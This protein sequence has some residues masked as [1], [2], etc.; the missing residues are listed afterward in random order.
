MNRTVFLDRDGVIMVNRPQHVR[1]WSDVEFLPGA[2]EGLA[3]LAR[4]TVDVVVVTNQAIVNRGQA[5]RAAVDEIH[6]RML[7]EIKRHGGGIRSVEVCPHR[8]DEGCGCRKPAPGLLLRAATRYGIRLSNAILVGDHEHD[9]EAAR[10]A[11]AASI[12]VLSGRTSEWPSDELPA[13]CV[14]VL[15]GLL[16]AAQFI[17]DATHATTDP[18]VL[19]RVP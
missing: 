9:L 16:E 15:P 19:A 12:L 4:W 10:R 17:V 1:S 5:S 2:L 18:P 13:G 8:P 11:E 7:V 6:A 3:L 14:A